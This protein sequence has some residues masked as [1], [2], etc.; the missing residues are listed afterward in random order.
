MK[1]EFKQYGVY[2][3]IINNNKIVLIKKH[4]GPYDGK[5]DL[6]GGGIKFHEQPEETLKRELK[7]EV[8]IEVQKYELFDADSV[9][10][11]WPY[12]DKIL[13]GHHV[14]IFYKVLE[15]TGDIKENVAIDDNNNDS[16]GAKYYD[17]NSLKKEDLSLIALLELEKIG[18]K[19]S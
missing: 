14:G 15:Y 8:G 19:F 12:E 13:D 9:T 10:F 11:E 5:L 18:Y 16:L 3:I 1:Q 2:G 17:I 4:G 6:P 7:E